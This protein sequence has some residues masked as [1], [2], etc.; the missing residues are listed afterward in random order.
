[1]VK[2]DYLKGIVLNRTIGVEVEGYSGD[3]RN[4]RNDG[5]RHSNLKYDGS[6]TGGRYGVQGVEVVTKPINNLDLLDE[7]FEDI[8]AYKWSIGRGTAG[9]HIHVDSNDYK[10]EDKLKMAIFMN[11]IELPMFLLV[12]KYRWSRR[13]YGRNQYC[14]PIQDGWK[15]VLKRLDENYSDINWRQYKKLG[16]LIYDLSNRSDRRYFSTPNTTRYQF[17]NIWSSSHDTIEFRIF[18]AIRDA[19]EAKKFALLAYSLVEIV[20]HS[21]LEHLEYIADVIMNK[22]TSAEDMV[23]K[24]TESVGLEHLTY[25]IQNKDLAYSIDRDKQRTTTT[26]FVAI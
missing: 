25:K 17:V 15:Q 22:S 9:T 5:I 11:L 13:K 8:T 23:K 12:K 10:L 14:R 2:K 3:Y 24:L 19:K 18:H 16:N 6:L 20:K 4:M 21:T 1:M 7:V 26:T